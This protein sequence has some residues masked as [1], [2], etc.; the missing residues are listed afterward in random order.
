MADTKG[1]PRWERWLRIPVV[2]GLATF[3][4]QC[5]LQRAATAPQY[6]GIAVSVLRDKDSPPELR[7]WATD[8]LAE[9][10]VVKLKKPLE[11]KFRDGTV[12]LPPAGYGE[13]G[14]GASAYGGARASGEANPQVEPGKGPS[15]GPVP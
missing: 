7:Q 4:G 5:A 11:E 15:L 3:V 2:V 8:V 1:E 6:V 9:Y 13:G 12:I 10:S 14:Y